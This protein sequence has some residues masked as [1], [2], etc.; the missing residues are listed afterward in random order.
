MSKAKGKN[1]SR[2]VSTRIKNE[3]KND[4]F[5]IL[6]LANKKKH[7]RKIKL[8]EL[9]ELAISLVKEE[10]IKMLQDQS[11]TNEDRKEILRQKYIQH[12][13][14]I[15][16]DEFT[17]FMMKPEFLDFVKEQELRN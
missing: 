7:G 2:Y 5:S 16:R 14:S 8:P 12:R 11:M 4:A 6:A 3:S 15:S 13:G 17:G 9:L 10:H 1:D